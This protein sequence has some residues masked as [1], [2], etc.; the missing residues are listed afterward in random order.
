MQLI[1]LTLAA[2]LCLALPSAS[3]AQEEP[4]RITR[5]RE[6]YN[7]GADAFRDGQF[8]EAL[9]RFSEAYELSARAELLYNIGTAHDRLGRR[10]DALSNYRAYLEALPGAHNRGYT[11]ARIAVLEREVAEAA[12]LEEAET[13]RQEE[14]CCV[15]EEPIAQPVAEG[16]AHVPAI[17]LVASAGAFGVAAAVTGALALGQRNELEDTCPGLVCESAQQESIDRLRS[18]SLATDVLIGAAAA[19]AAV[20][21]ILFIVGGGDEGEAAV[22]CGLQ[23]CRVRVPF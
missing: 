13:R 1:R 6:A 18:L 11:E 12:A 3:N 5:A 2:F 21:V 20:G 16:R 22:G 14:R 19:A 10:G 7:E 8:G 9:D 23:G 15:E 17:V 4:E